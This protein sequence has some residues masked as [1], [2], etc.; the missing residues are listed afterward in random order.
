MLKAA[1]STVD[2]RVA[3]SAQTPQTSASPIVSSKNGSPAA[4]SVA[5]VAPNSWY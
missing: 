3:P 2:N 5:P 1:N 4:K